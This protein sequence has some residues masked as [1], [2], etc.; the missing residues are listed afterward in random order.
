M[1][2]KPCSMDIII[3]TRHNLTYKVL[4]ITAANGYIAL[5]L[6]YIIRVM[7]IKIG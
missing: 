3:I 6:F 1:L 4:P 2:Q 5:E 7:I